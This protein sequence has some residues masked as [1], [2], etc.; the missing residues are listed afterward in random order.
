MHSSVGV[1]DEHV[2][3]ATLLALD[4]LKK[5]LNFSLICGVADD[6]HTVSAP[7]FNLRLDQTC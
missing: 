7:F 5:V 3:S 2:K 6:W 4:S 1:V